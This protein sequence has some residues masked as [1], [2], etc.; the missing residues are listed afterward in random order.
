MTR[1][2]SQRMRL[3]VARAE[4]LGRSPSV[5][6]DGRRLLGRRPVSAGTQTADDLRVEDVK[7]PR[8]RSNLNDPVRLGKRYTVR[9]AAKISG[10]NTRTLRRWLVGEY[11]S[12]RSSGPVFRA[13]TSESETP[14]SLSFIELIEVVIAAEFR[15]RRIK[16]ER[17]RSGRDFMRREWGFEYP[18]AHVELDSVGGEIL[19]HF[20]EQDPEAPALAVS[21]DG[22]QWTLPGLVSLRVQE[23][24]HL[25]DDGF[26]IRWYPRGR[27][28]P[29]MVDP[30]FAAGR[31][32]VANRGVT[33]D[34]IKRRSQG[35]GQS[36][37]DIA[38]DLHVTELA[39]VTTHLRDT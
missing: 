30:R 6:S 10:V 20:D 37:E 13:E 2:K 39:V 34:I 33:V 1:Q 32:A 35:T 15:R 18:F 25:Q 7:R 5:P 28:V 16:I 29:I 36:V 38:H 19:H 9:D 11:G 14:L 17:I 31:P 21:T 22:M 27:K 24:V 12:N 3:R 8:L 4:R 26:A 23:F